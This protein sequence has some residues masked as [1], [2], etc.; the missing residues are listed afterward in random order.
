MGQS[1]LKEGN[2]KKKVEKQ[3]SKKIK[4]RISSAKSGMQ[5][6][7]AGD[8]SGIQNE[9]AIEGMTETSK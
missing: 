7:N 3:N 6:L 1:A 5:A 9:I 8:R 2:K 4:M